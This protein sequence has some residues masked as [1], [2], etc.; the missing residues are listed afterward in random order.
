MEQNWQ[1]FVTRSRRLSLLRFLKECGGQANDSI[2]QNVLEN[3][4]GFSKN[5]RETYRQ[6]I[7]FCEDHGLV[8]VSW[9]GEIMVAAI[10]KR[11]VE[12][13][14]GRSKVEGIQPPSVGV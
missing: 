5:P 11:G 10:T 2:I 9:A 1:A 8:I 12:V 7:R 6:D 13:A 14:E 3:T 4:Y